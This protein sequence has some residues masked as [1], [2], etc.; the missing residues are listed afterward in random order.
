LV[1]EG[2]EMNEDSSGFVHLHNHTEYSLLDGAVRIHDLVAQAKKMGMPAIAITDHGNMYGVVEFY[3]AAKAEGIT[4]I[5]GCEVYVAPESRFSK[6]GA[7]DDSAY[8]LVLLAENDKGYKNLMHLV[9]L[10]HREGFYY[11]PRVDKEILRQHHE[12]LIALSACLGGQIPTMLLQGNKEGA[13]A[14]ALEMA[15]I[16]GR[17]NFFLE[18]QD[19]GLM[20]QKTVNQ[21]LVE[22]SKETGI[23]LVATNDLHYLTQDDAEAHDVLLCIQTAK[24][25]D[26]LDRMRFPSDQFYLKSAQEMGELFAWCPE[27]LANTVAIAQRCD[28]TLQFGTYHL[29]DYPVPQG[30]TVVT[31][32]R[33]LCQE[34]MPNRYPNPSPKILERLEYELSVIENMGYP[35]YFLIVWDFC[36]FAHRNGIPVGPGRGS[37]AASI[38]A[39]ILGITDIDPLPYNLLF[40]RFLNPERVSMPDFDIDFCYERRG[41]VIEYVMEKYGRE[42]VAQIITFGTM[43]ARGVV[44]DV[45]RTMNFPYS[46][47]DRIA[48]LIPEEL[49][50]TIDRALEQEPRLKEMVDD[51]PRVEKLISIARKLEGLSR[52]ASTHAAGVVI[53]KEDLV[54]Y[55]PL[56]GNDQE[57]LTTQ[58]PMTTLE[59]L[60]LLKMDFLGLR[61]LTILKNT[62][63]MIRANRGLDIDLNSIPLDDKAT[64]DLLCSADTMAVFQ[65]ESDGM[66]KVL[67]ELQP[68]VFEDI[69]ALVALYRPGPMEQIPNFIASKHGK[70]PVSY[71]HPDLEDILKETYGVMIYQEQI[72]LVASTL[73]GFTLGQAD[74]LRRAIGKKKMAEMKEQRKAFVAGCLKNGIDKKQSEDIYDLIVKFADYGFNKSHSAAYG[75][76]A[77][78]TAYFKANYTLE[79]MAANLG[80]VMANTDKVALYIDHCRRQGIQVLPPDINESGVDFTVVGD[81]IRFGLGAVKNL[82]VAA[83]EELL[84]ERG[85]NGPFVSL[86]DFCNRMNGR[87]NKRMLE[88]MIKGGC[89]DSLPGHRAQKLAAMDNLLAIALRLY[90]QKVSGQM[91][92]FDLIEDPEPEAQLPPIE[93][94]PRK[95]MLQGEK[96]AL[97]VY[98]SGHPLEDYV[99]LLDS[100]NVAPIPSL[101]EMQEGKEVTV[102]GMAA[103]C[104]TMLT[105]KG[106]HMAFL[107]LEDQ[108]TIVEVIIFDEI[109]SQSRELLTGDFP[110]L[111][112][113]RLEFATQGDPKLRALRICKLEA[114][115]STHKLYLK[116]EPNTDQDCINRVLYVLD[117]YPGDVPVYLFF[118]ETKAL[119]LMDKFPVNPDKR[120]LDQLEQTLGPDCVVLKTAEKHQVK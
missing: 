21:D 114:P 46:E 95:E 12:G 29:P 111:V 39:Y 89:M 101:V 58:L 51:D 109:L 73:A 5:L 28:V 82:G 40:E 38:V 77:Y 7:R 112:T 11:K 70:V 88:N 78:Q 56:Q 96:D 67:S 47:T 36:D 22:I 48:K 117:Q 13:K 26:D 45:G 52:H 102:A 104:R 35:S 94:F 80:S 23:S 14:L 3:K 92:I 20:E 19:H 81:K 10:G 66:R 115:N 64:F 55:V 100:L 61:T 75:L 27:A 74:I 98:L 106:K 49:K 69:I 83:V 43:A 116:F 57:G 84:S 4:P 76:V 72:M 71:P 85:E 90:K 103:A 16:F 97:G 31:W 99:E 54:N 15:D 118:A 42:R 93:P 91:D 60:G 18:L 79:F 44:R 24:H 110:L 59:E 65:F 108:F 63:D 6:Q 107:T 87:C 34:K 30:H 62:L 2:I 37:G 1:P 17:E 68:T 53:S 50:M 105:R 32:L 113:G 9:T 119:R 33:L 25:I 120:L 41:E 86:A 8:H